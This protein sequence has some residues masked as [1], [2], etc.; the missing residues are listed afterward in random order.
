METQTNHARYEKAISHLNKAIELKPDFAIAY[1]NVAASC[2]VI[3]ARLTVPL[4]ILTR[5]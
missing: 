2:T 4:R 5:Q 1:N 3:R